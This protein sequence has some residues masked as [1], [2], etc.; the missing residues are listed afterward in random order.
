MSS[1]IKT[2]LAGTLSMIRDK[3]NIPLGKKSIEISTSSFITVQD[4][5]SHLVSKGFG[6]IE[7]LSTE[8]PIKHLPLYIRISDSLYKINPTGTVCHYSTL[9]LYDALNLSPRDRNIV[10]S[11]LRHFNRLFTQSDLITKDELNKAIQ[12]IVRMGNDEYLENKKRMINIQC[13]RAEMF[14]EHK[15][16]KARA[17]KYA[18]RLLWIGFGISAFQCAYIG[19]GTYMVFSWDFMEPQAYA[20]NLGNFILAYATYTLRRHEMSRDQIFQ[21]LT[22]NRMERIS[23][24]QGFDLER[25]EEITKELESLKNKI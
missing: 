18:R 16:I 22:Q 20:I 10:Q 4:L 8:G 14:E 3:L 11:H 5:R 19:V 23:K 12:M 7:F 9:D 21:I 1:W 15:H 13:E 6:N 24:I 25:F 17:E 2:P